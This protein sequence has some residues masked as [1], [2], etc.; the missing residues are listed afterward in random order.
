MCY[1]PLRQYAHNITWPLLLH[2]DWYFPTWSSLCLC[3]FYYGI[4]HKLLLCLLL[5]FIYIPS[6]LT[7]LIWLFLSRCVL[8][9][10][11][12]NWLSQHWDRL[13]KCIE[14]QAFYC[15]DWSISVRFR[16][17]PDISSVPPNRSI[18]WEAVLFHHSSPCCL[19]QFHSILLFRLKT[20]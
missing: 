14:H 2:L 8:R 9:K 15:F 10:R 11:F 13:K 17:R 6:Q 12:R 18:F 19:Q 16:D 1:R 4:L 5:N 3:S 20:L 7:L